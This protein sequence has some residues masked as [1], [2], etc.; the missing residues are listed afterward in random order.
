MTRSPSDKHSAAALAQL[1][2]FDDPLDLAQCESLP[3]ER[4]LHLL[5]CW[6]A[7]T[8]EKNRREVLNAILTLEGK[9]VLR[10]DEPDD[11]PRV[12]GYGVVDR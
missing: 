7:T 12:R 10:E 4:R 11:S 1:A 5:Q 2:D 8:E 3:H 6:L 9:A